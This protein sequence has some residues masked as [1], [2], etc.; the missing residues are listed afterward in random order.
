MKRFFFL[1]TGIFSAIAFFSICYCFS[2]QKS[3]NRMEMQKKQRNETP[4]ITEIVVSEPGGDVAS[5]NESR[6]EQ[7]TSDDI[8]ITPDTVCVYE[9]V[10]LDTGETMHYEAKPNAEIAGLNRIQLKNI[11]SKYVN[12]MPVT[13]FE[14]GLVS[15]ELLSFSAERVVMQKVYDGKKVRYKYYVTLKNDEVVVY[16]SDK[17]TVFEYTGIR[18]ESLEDDITIALKIG[19]PVNDVESLYDYLSGITS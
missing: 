1:F 10:S 11:L 12:N 14:Q 17:K 8:I 7:V 18:C 4:E 13:E 9:I 19:I 15:Y 5:A 6:I 16:Y 2:F 3:V